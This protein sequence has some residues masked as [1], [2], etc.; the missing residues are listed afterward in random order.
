M[1]LVAVVI[2][3]SCWVEGDTNMND[4]KSQKKSGEPSHKSVGSYILVHGSSE[5][6]GVKGRGLE[7]VSLDANS[8]FSSRK[9][10]FERG[11]VWSRFGGGVG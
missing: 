4:V 8:D 2:C 3:E 1:L 7:N 11:W 6:Q 5:S 9:K 10:R